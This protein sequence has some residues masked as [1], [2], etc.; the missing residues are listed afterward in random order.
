MIGEPMGLVSVI[1]SS[2]GIGVTS[3]DVTTEGSLSD[4]Q[5]AASR[6][7]H[8]YLPHP[9][10]PLF[11]SFLPLLTKKE[12]VHRLHESFLENDPPSSADPSIRREMRSPASTPRFLKLQ[13]D[14]CHLLLNICSPYDRRRLVTRVERV[15]LATIVYAAPTLGSVKYH[16]FTTGS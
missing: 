6:L 2:V 11:K 1:G 4:H 14:C 12:N 3:S 13:R 8:D 15:H 5:N 10:R 7:Q 9:R 16:H